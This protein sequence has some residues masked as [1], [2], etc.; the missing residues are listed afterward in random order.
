VRAERSR[1]RVGAQGAGATVSGGGSAESEEAGGVDE[2]ASARC[3]GRV[4]GALEEC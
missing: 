2:L 3:A 1:W 4:L